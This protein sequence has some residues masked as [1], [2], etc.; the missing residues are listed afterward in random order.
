MIL[1]N[2]DLK[3]IAEIIRSKKRIAILTH[4]NIDGDCLGGAAALKL[5]LEKSTDKEVKIVIKDNLAEEYDFMSQFLF[6][7]Y[8]ND[9]P[10]ADL[11]LALDVSNP[12]ILCISEEEIKKIHTKTIV[13]DHHANGRPAEIGKIFYVDDS[14]SSA[15]EIV[16]QTL[17]LLDLEITKEIATCLLAGIEP[18]TGSFQYSNTN[19]ETLEA[20]S[21]LILSGARLSKIIDKTFLNIPVEH[22]KLRGL[23]IE[24]LI[25]NK[26]YG[27]V[28]SYI[29]LQ[30]LDSLDLK[31]TASGLSNFLDVLGD[32]N[33]LFM[34]SEEKEGWLKISLRSRRDHIDLSIFAKALGG[35]GHKGASG[36]LI[37]GKINES[38]K[39]VKVI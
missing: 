18:D 16:L 6:T 13:I 35:G 4:R 15:S 21:E 29:N 3:E 32:I 30:D 8:I 17:K 34:I 39:E 38:S 28:V 33:I 20:A 25:Y 7:P 27:V 11:Y 1:K 5:A 26:K 36:F 12:M 37:Q 19:P 14:S 22:L 31:E 9:L 24:R 2:K 10:E 23:V